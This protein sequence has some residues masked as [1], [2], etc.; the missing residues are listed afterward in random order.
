[1]KNTLFYRMK[2]QMN[3]KTCKQVL[4]ETAI[5]G[6]DIS[7]S[8]RAHVAQ[9]RSC[10][11]VVKK[12]AELEHCLLS[13]PELEPPAN[14]K[15][16]V[17]ERAA[18]K[19]PRWSFFPAL[20]PV[21]RAAGILIILVSGFWLGLQT[22]NGGDDPPEDFDITRDTAYRLNVRALSPENLGEVYFALLEEKEN[23]N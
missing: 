17:L 13:A 7:A 21:L 20:G 3:K 2:K 15:S 6:A 8:A 23:G 11:A 10:A 14:L 16:A 12:E 19:T 18:R 9:C 1:M 22:A 5:S 4:K